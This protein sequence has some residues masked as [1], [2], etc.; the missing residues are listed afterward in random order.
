MLKVKT[1]AKNSNQ[2]VIL[3]ELFLLRENM[4]L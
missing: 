2:T 3:V 4:V 1:G